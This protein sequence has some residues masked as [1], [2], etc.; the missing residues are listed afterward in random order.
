MSTLRLKEITGVIPAMVTAFDENEVLDESRIRANAAFLL[1]RN[2]DGLYL[3]GSTGEAFLMS[4]D[5]RKRTVEIVVDEIAGRIPIIAHI[6][7]IG[8]RLSVDLAEHAQQT[9]VDAISSVPPFYWKFS[10]DQIFNYYK[11]LTEAVDL[12]MIA[13]N[14]PL[15]GLFGFD[16]IKRL[17]SIKGVE[18]IKYTAPT[19]FEI[20]RIKEEISKD[21]V[22]YS[23]ADEMAMSGLCFGADGIIGSFYNLMPEIFIGIKDAVAQGD[24]P[25]AKSLQETANAIIFF[26]LSRNPTAMI[27]RGMAWQGSDAGYCRKPFDNFYS[28][29]DEESLKAECRQLMQE[30]N[31]EGVVFLDAISS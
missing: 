11:D 3:A 13:Y 28:Q 21:F 24:L 26:A 1:K 5:E 18:G 10:E 22:V 27:K 12:P 2:V 31:L 30:R 23:G 9:G 4:T 8:T 6:G 19:H 15:A 20:M 16:L 25:K 17:A 7:A 14:L 29:Q